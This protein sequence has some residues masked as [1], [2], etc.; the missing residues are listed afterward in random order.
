[1]ININLLQAEMNIVKLVIQSSNRINKR[2]EVKKVEKYKK[3]YT[4]NL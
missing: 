3:L 1:M 4:T 2:E